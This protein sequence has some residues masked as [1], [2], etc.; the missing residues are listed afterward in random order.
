LEH[1][2]IGRPTAGSSEPWQTGQPARLKKGPKSS[3]LWPNHSAIARETDL[4]MVN[5]RPSISRPTLSERL[6][7]TDG[8]GKLFCQAPIA[9]LATP[10]FGGNRLEQNVLCR[11]NNASCARRQD[12]RQMRIRDDNK[13]SHL[14]SALIHALALADQVDYEVRR[15]LFALERGASSPPRKTEVS[16]RPCGLTSDIQYAIGRRLPEVYPLEQSVPAGVA[17]LLSQ[18]EQQGNQLPKRRDSYPRAA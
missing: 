12:G 11:V 15:W 13:T 16:R 6:W 5:P 9:C 3:R 14:K 4:I 18:F 2:A 8:V 10:R 1:R 17:S 7:R